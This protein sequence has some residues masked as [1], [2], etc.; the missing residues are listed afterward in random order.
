MAILPKLPF[1]ISK[2][3]KFQKSRKFQRCHSHEV[4]YQGNYHPSD[5]KV[6]KF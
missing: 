1:E 6:H 4:V 5:N 3:A 2:L